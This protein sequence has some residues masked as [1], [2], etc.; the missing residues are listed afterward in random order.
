MSNTEGIETQYTNPG[1]LEKAQSRCRHC[2]ALTETDDEAKV[3][4][5]DEGNCDVTAVLNCKEWTDE[6]IGRIN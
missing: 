5:C 2:H 3:W 1:L 4:W 6:A